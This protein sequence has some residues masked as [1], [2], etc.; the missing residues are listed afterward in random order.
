M[1][2]SACT[3]AG[4]A[5]Y[6]AR[7]CIVHAH[8]K[9]TLSRSQ[10]GPK[11]LPPGLFKPTAARALSTSHIHATD[12]NSRYDALKRQSS[13]TESLLNTH[14]DRASAAKSAAG[15][16]GSD[17][18]FYL[19]IRPSAQEL[20]KGYKQ[21]SELGVGGKMARTGA[22]A[23][24]SVVILAGAA[25]TALLVY[26]LATELGSRNSPTVIYADVCELIKEHNGLR[27]MLPAG[28]RI[29]F[30]TTAPRSSSDRPR[31]RN[32]SVPSA[33]VLDSAGIEHLYLNFW[34]EATP[35][36][37]NTLTWRDAEWWDVREWDWS[38][39]HARR[40]ISDSQ[41]TAWR[42][43][44]ELFAMLTGQ[45]L[46]KE[47]PDKRHARGEQDS[48]ASSSS[49]VSQPKSEG[50]SISGALWS[51]LTGVLRPISTASA[52]SRTRKE[53]L[54]Y[55]SGE[56][57]VDLIRDSTNNYVYRYVLVDLPNSSGAASTRIFVK[58][59]AGVAEHESVMRFS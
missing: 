52:A 17:G 23:S 34:I 58:R 10:A 26:A 22:R 41:D 1:S 3:R 28:S 16:P 42:Q 27:N 31:H 19:G 15:R 35:D 37:S 8:L 54:Q 55:T 4:K 5:L 12:S 50:R 57:H 43:G 11:R 39:A 30:H 33:V 44:R 24:S 36:T 32:R 47:E 14:M 20:P 49:T 51:T 40:W 7:E 13:Q 38:V 6:A 56:V 21:W 48:S 25:L 18:V 45:P 46:P 9:Q 29:K 53:P 2:L 59:A